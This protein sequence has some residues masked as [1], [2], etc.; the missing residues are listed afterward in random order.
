MSRKIQISLTSRRPVSV[1]ADDWPVIASARWFDN[2]HEF[3]AYRKARVIVR[4]HEDGRRIVYAWT[5]SAHYFE[6][7]LHAGYVLDAPVS[8]PAT[9]A[10]IERVAEEIDRADLG[11]DCIA[12]LPAED[13]A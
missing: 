4:E 7:E 9:V 6:R 13:L 12:D 8:E 11:R 2:E 5:S 10:A 3:Q 1:D